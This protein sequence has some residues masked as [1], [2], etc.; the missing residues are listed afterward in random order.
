[1]FWHGLLSL[2][3]LSNLAGFGLD[4]GLSTTIQVLVLLGFAAI[5]PVGYLAVCMASRRRPR[6]TGTR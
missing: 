5:V 3:R 1:M 6:W 2:P 4:P